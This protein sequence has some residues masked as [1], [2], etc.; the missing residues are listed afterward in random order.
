MY[1]SAMLGLLGGPPAGQSGPVLEYIEKRTCHIC[2]LLQAACTILKMPCANCKCSLNC[3]LMNLVQ[4][5]DLQSQ[6]SEMSLQDEKV[7]RAFSEPIAPT[8]G[9][10]CFLS[11]WVCLHCNVDSR[12]HS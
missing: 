11:L 6:M 9:T 1:I 4:S 5:Y 7:F 2:S 12:Q 3:Q 10:E 8:E